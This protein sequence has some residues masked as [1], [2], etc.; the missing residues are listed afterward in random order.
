MNPPKIPESEKITIEE[1]HIGAK[2]MLWAKC[3][4]RYLNGGWSWV[5][6]VY[7][8]DS[9]RLHKMQELIEQGLIKRNE[10]K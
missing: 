10:L 6:L 5:G 9:P 1:I 2:Y 8:F 7:N 3:T 4:E